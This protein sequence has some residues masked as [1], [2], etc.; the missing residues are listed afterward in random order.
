MSQLSPD[1]GWEQARSDTAGPAAQDVYQ[2]RN[3]D[4]DNRIGD[5][6]SGTPRAAARSGRSAKHP[7]RHC[8]PGLRSPRNDTGRARPERRGRANLLV[9]DNPELVAEL[10]DSEADKAAPAE[11]ARINVGSR[12]ARPRSTAPRPTSRSHSL[13]GRPVDMWTIGVADRLRFSAP[14]ASWEGREMLALAHIP[15]GTAANKGF[16]VN[17][18]KDSSSAPAVAIA[19]I[20][21]DIETGRA[22]P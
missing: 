18:V 17:G 1:L 22:K 19:T 5:L 2:Q 3:L 14:R 10:R 15:T 12:S 9:I 6:V 16:D 4:R 21:A 13:R 20:G 11:L 7:D 8:R